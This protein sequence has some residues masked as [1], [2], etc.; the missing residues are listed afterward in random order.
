MNDA[1]LKSGRVAMF[2]LLESLSECAW[3]QD[4]TTGQTW[5]SE[6]FWE[7]LGHDPK[8]L[9]LSREVAREFLHTEDLSLAAAE[10]ELHREAEEPFEI[11]VRVH[12]N[13]QGWRWLRMRGCV[14]MWRD[15]HPTCIGGIIKDITE[16]VVSAR[17]QYDAEGLVG[18]LTKREREVLRLSSG[19]RSE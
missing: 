2:K 3:Q 11:E 9:P 16:R 10:V 4:L 12:T 6:S 19:R 7:G 13:N 8:T 18:T 14:T 5:I 17:A 15:G 1:T